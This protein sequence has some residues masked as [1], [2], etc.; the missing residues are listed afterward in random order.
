[1]K[2]LSEITFHSKRIHSNY[3]M[4]HHEH[5]PLKHIQCAACREAGGS[6]RCTA[7]PGHPDNYRYHHNRQGNHQCQQLQQLLSLAVRT[8]ISVP[9]LS[10]GSRLETRPADLDQ[11]TMIMQYVCI[12]DTT[13]GH[14]NSTDR[15]GTGRRNAPRCIYTAAHTCHGRD[16]SNEHAGVHVL[17]RACHPI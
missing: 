14:A 12:Y 2:Q 7:K 8:L 6:H 5:K 11:H 16:R 17:C 4:S 3:D 10:Q 15:L 13:H 1:M 9:A